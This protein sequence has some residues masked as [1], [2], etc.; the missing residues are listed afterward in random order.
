MK[1]F[2]KL[3]VCAFVLTFATAAFAGEGRLTLNEDAKV[4]GTLVKAG[5]YKVEWT[6]AG[7]V[8]IRKGR[9]VV[10]SATATVTTAARKSRLNAATLVKE[11]DGSKRVSQ[12]EFGGKKEVLKL[13]GGTSSDSTATTN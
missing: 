3:S 7:S 1:K 12:I 13:S 11:S 8:S 10:A 9:E 4:N 6:E 5:E 2:M